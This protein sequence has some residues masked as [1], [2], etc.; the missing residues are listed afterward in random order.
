MDERVITRL[1]SGGGA[2]HRGCGSRGGHHHS[3][4]LHEGILE[5][6]KTLLLGSALLLLFAF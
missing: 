5:I 1:D 2:G 3:V 6:V 4:G